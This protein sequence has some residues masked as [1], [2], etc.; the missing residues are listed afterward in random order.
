MAVGVLLAGSVAAQG[1]WFDLEGRPSLALR[2]AVDI[3]VGATADGL[4]PEDYQAARLARDLDRLTTDEA[5]AVARGRLE[6]EV[7]EALRHYL[8]DLHFGR[9]DPRQIHENFSLPSPAALDVGAYLEAALA[10]GDLPEAVRQAAPQ[11]PL[12]AVLRQVLAR[13]REMAAQPAATAAW[14]KPLPAFAGRKLEPGKEYAGVELLAQRL[15]FWGDLAEVVSVGKNYDGPLVTGVKAFQ[16]RHGLTA[17]GVVGKATLAQ[18]AVT[19]AE[20]VRQI[21]L[22]LE[23]L[24]WTPLLDG[25]RL[26]VVNVPE[27]MLRAYE[28]RDGRVELKAAMK[29]IV[30]KAM[31]TRTPVFAEDMRYIEFS[32]YW[33]VPPSIA[34]EETVPKL[35]RDPAYFQ[36]QGFEFVN[37][38]GQPVAELSEANLQAVLQGRLRIR[39]RPG[40]KNALGDIKFV[41]PNNDNI[42]LHHTPA[43]SLFQR[44][45]RDFSHGCIRVE[46]PVALARFVLENEPEWTPERIRQAMAKGESNIWRLAEPL[47]VVI[48]YSTAIAKRDGKVYFFPDLYGHDRLLDELLTLHSRALRTSRPS[49]TSA[50]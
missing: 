38:A 49:A 44:D 40:T 8:R 47:R 21:E 23:R 35:R 2:Q 18:L 50:E 15:N 41:F 4:D 28:N 7:S 12:Y 25:P 9:I 26:V 48:A 34:R 13:Y 37:G 46:D 36:Q 10:R 30:G 45:R 17:D 43:V 16:E 11:V 31:N 14:A 29:V 19:P 1:P 33:N 6:M 39:Q 32:P 42:Y 27:F 5:N 22:T 20:R 24:R 3:L